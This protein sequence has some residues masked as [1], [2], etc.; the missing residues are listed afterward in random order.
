[1]A[2]GNYASAN[3]PLQ[4][5]NDG[6]LAG[7]YRNGLQLVHTDTWLLIYEFAL[8]APQPTADEPDLWPIDTWII[9]R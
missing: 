7:L 2:A 3:M 4:S 1:M 6:Y 8:R 5:W 9:P